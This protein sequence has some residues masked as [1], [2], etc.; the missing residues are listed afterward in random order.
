MVRVADG[1]QNSVCL[2]SLRSFVAPVNENISIIEILLKYDVLIFQ[3]VLQSWEFISVV[4]LE[5][6]DSSKPTTATTT[7]TTNGM[8]VH[9][10]TA[11]CSLSLWLWFCGSHSVG[12]GKF[13]KRQLL[14]WA[15]CQDVM[16]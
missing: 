10:A 14:G 3:I 5:S 13:I 12:R 8:A 15:M 16:K 2:C 7:S 1:A 6:R 9:A 11:S 4:L